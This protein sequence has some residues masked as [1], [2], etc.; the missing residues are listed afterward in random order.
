MAVTIGFAVPES[1]EYTRECR[2]RRSKNVGE[3][4]CRLLCGRT[5][6]SSCLGLD[7]TGRRH[8]NSRVGRGMHAEFRNSLRGTRALEVT[9]KRLGT[10]S[11][12]A[13]WVSK[14]I[15]RCVGSNDC[16]S[17]EEDPASEHE[18]ARGQRKCE[19]YS[20][21]VERDIPHWSCT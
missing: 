9:S 3:K 16:G 15:C 7:R 14:S 11:A 5:F 12:H 4:I 1:T 10:L 13:V 21:I 8:E 19:L 20:G 6:S 17:A 18:Q 2:E